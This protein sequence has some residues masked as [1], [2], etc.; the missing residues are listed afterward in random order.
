MATSDKYDR[1]LRLWGA[2]G[3]KL[4]MTSHILLI[5]ADAVGTETL[6]N[7]VL[8]GIG[9]FTILDDYIVDANDLG[10]NF[11][12]IPQSIGKPRAEVVT[13]LLCEMNSDVN[14]IA[15]VAN[16][17]N[18]FQTEPAF[19][20]QFQLIIVANLPYQHVIALSRLCQE[21]QIPLILERAYGLIGIVRL[22]LSN[23]EI[24]ESKSDKDSY[25]VRVANPFPELIK[26]CD[27][28]DLN[29]LDSLQ[30]S[31]IPYLVILYK[32]ITLYKSEHDGNIPRTYAEKESF[33]NTIKS[34]ARN[35]SDELNFHEAVKESYRAYTTKQLYD[36]AIDL[37]KDYSNISLSEKSKIFDFLV[38]ALIEFMEINNGDIPLSGRLPDMT[39][40]TETFVQLQH[41]FQQKAHTD[42]LLFTD[43]VK[44]K[45]QEFGRNI[46]SVPSDYI[47]TFCKNTFNIMNITTRTISDEITSLDNEETASSI[48]SILTDDTFEQD[49]VQTPLLWYLT[50]RAA[51]QF[52]EKYAR[53]PGSLFNNSSL[54]S[55]QDEVYLQLS[56]IRK[57]FG[58]TQ[59]FDEIGNNN[60]SVPM[61]VDDE[62]DGDKMGVWTLEKKDFYNHAIEITRYGGSQLHTISSFVGGI[63]SQEAIKIITHQYIPLNNTYVFNGIASCGGT[64]NL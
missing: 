56:I 17:Q 40:T 13:E 47:E 63:A 22:Q 43:I 52:Y 14:G 64:Y 59:P 38:S 36:E 27:E 32:A 11:F 21:Y 48:R 19:F 23:H 45:L 54:Q 37:V 55:D 58:L 39:S 42:L 26:F 28:I 2:N 44:K 7:L 24:I 61:T 6:K 35:Y 12:T 34:L 3:Q 25:D 9:A 49:C 8:P 50:L 31:H 4:L 1:Q 29:N 20:S 51:D 5:N 16:F 30:H 10:N 41:I 46:E 53:W 18:V 62:G 60:S 33:K 57:H 15:K